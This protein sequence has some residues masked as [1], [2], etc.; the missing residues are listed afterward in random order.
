MSGVACLAVTFSAA[1]ITKQVSKSLFRS[2]DAWIAPNRPK[3]SLGPQLGQQPLAGTRNELLHS[4]ACALWKT[5]LPQCPRAHFTVIPI[6]LAHR[7][8][9]FIDRREGVWYNIM[10]GEKRLSCGGRVLHRPRCRCKR[11]LEAT[12]QVEAGNEADKWCVCGSSL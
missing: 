3:S 8:A 12:L 11:W 2:H 10:C 9:L 6:C 7:I 5:R 1:R 4:E